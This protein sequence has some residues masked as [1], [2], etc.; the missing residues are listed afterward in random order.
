MPTARG[1]TALKVV[2]RDGKPALEPGWV[3][4]E[5]A[6][7][8]TPIIVNGVVFAVSASTTGASAA[9]V[10]KRAKP[11]VLYAMDGTDGREL[12]TSGTVMSSFFA[13][14]SF[15]SANGQVYV[16]TFDGTLYAFGF[17]MERKH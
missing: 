9:E 7:P 6:S 5:I 4:R 17:P 15:W 10:A 3:S 13:G 14:R 2:E 16:G 12:W 11:A 8:V 1:I